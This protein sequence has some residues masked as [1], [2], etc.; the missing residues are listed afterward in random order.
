MD[1]I[2]GPL[3]DL[4]ARLR[5]SEPMAGWQAVEGW[6]EVVGDRVAARARA[7]SFREGTLVVEVDSP[8]WMNELTYLKQRMIQDLNRKLG[9]PIV[10]D[11]RLQPAARR[12]AERPGRSGE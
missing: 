7:V 8:T 12:S 6:P 3:R 10:R 4:L 11:I 9:S 2:G 1:R 5:L